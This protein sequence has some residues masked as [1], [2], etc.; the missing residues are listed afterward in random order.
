MIDKDLNWWK[1]K[2]Y[3]RDGLKSKL[4]TY[5]ANLVDRH[6][7]KLVKWNRAKLV[8]NK[9]PNWWDEIVLS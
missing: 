2:A 9:E 1:Y 8:K 7:A 3:L 4:V 5:R 6:R